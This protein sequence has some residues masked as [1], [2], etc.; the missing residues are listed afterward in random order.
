MKKI[1]FILFSIFFYVSTS[2]AEENLPLMY[3]IIPEDDSKN[4]SIIDSSS[5]T[6]LNFKIYS[7]QGP[8]YFNDK[9]IDVIDKH[10]KIDLSGLTGKQEIRFTNDDKEEAIFTYYIS[11]E[12]GLLKEY[13]LA[14]KQAYIKSVDGIKL[15]Y[16]DKDAK[17]IG[18][19]SDLINKVPAHVK[20]NVKEIKFFPVNHSSNAAGITDYNKIALYNLSTYTDKEIKRIVF[21]EIA[22]TWAHELRKDK[23][24]DYSYTEYKK[25]IEK[26]GNFVT[27]YSK[28]CASEDFADS[29]AFYLTDAKSFTK[30][31]SSRA[32]Y[33]LSLI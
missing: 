9:E 14:E 27:N 26:D 8:I 23:K 3:N 5:Q 31:F 15:I 18:Y 20:K 32:N 22:H 6:E 28:T 16:T 12:N 2:F 1:F 4:D 25:A 21:H 10:F 24:I 17:K 7:N 11:D 30:K 29:V 13:G 33:I 19:V